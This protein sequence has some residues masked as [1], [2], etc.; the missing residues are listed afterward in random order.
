MKEVGGVYIWQYRSAQSQQGV[1]LALM[2]WFIAALALLVSGVALTAKTEIRYAGIQLAKARVEAAADGAALIYLAEL[3]NLAPEDEQP[4]PQMQ[5][6]S[7]VGHLRITP[8]S[9]LINYRYASEET[10]TQLFVYA[11][12]LEA[13][14]AAIL[15]ESVIQWREFEAVENQKKPDGE[16]AGIF[17]L[18]D[19]MSVQ[20]LTRDI[21]EKIRPMITV[22]GSSTEVD[23][24]TAPI[25]VIRALLGENAEQMELQYSEENTQDSVNYL[26]SG[27]LRVDIRI[28]TGSGIFERSLW[29]VESQ[30]YSFGF[31]IDRKFPAIGVSSLK[32][33]GREDDK[34]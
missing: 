13:A 17:V 33:D 1:A 22:K 27:P 5:I 30:G 29:V 2:L 18:E 20:G 12:G 9:G 7:Y 15:S 19:I 21:F 8:A 23:L 25:E 11:A 10:L 31:R 4:V 6:G 24:E 34:Q 16:A 14:D 26:P 28:D 3:K 32:F